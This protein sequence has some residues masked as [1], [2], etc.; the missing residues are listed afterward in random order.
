M[1]PKQMLEKLWELLSK[2]LSKTPGANGVKPEQ[3]SGAPSV[4]DLLLSMKRGLVLSLKMSTTEECLRFRVNKL[5]AADPIEVIPAEGTR[6][7]YIFEGY[8]TTG[9]WF[10]AAYDAQTRVG[11]IYVRPTMAAA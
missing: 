10:S 8:A 3:I 2:A 4:D 5:V 7:M 9:N 6:K 11:Y 1:A